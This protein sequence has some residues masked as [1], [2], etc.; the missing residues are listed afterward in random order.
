MKI[1]CL[2]LGDFQ[3]NCYVLRPD[4]ASKDCLIIDPGLQARTL[5]D[6]L[7]TH[8]LEPAAVILTHGHIDHIAGISLLRQRYPGIQVCIHPAD[9]DMLADPT[10]NLS[11]MTG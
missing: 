2:V 7:I 11:L 6:F 10:A 1:D 5:L 4:A 9:A 3:T 8:G